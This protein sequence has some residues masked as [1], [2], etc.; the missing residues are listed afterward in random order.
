MTVQEANQIIYNAA[1]NQGLP[2]LIAQF[3][4]AQAEVESAQYTSDVYNRC[5]N[6]FGYKW[7][8]QDTAIGPCTGSPEGDNYADY[9]DLNQS[10]EEVAKWIL[11]RWDQF[12]NVTT[13]E[14]YADVLKANGYFG[15]SLSAYEAGVSRYWNQI[16]NLFQTAVEKYPTEVVMTGVTFFTLLGYFAYRMLRKK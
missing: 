14:Q 8:G 9:M 2:P 6:A 5:S 16:K 15:G 10:A 3:M 4:A 1:I 11:R 13:P 12:E 7:V